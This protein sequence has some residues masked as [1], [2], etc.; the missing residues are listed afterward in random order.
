MDL[1]A[2]KEIY[3]FDVFFEEKRF[4]GEMQFADM[5]A[6]NW[7]LNTYKPKTILE[8]G[9]W[10]GSCTCLF[11]TF[12]RKY[13]G[14]VYSIDNFKGSPGSAQ[15]TTCH[16]AKDRFL[17]NIKRFGLEDTV[18]LLEGSSNDYADLDQTFDMVFIDAD[19]R[20]SQVKKDIENFAPK[21][22]SCGILSGHDFNH[23]DY[24]EKHIEEDY[25]T[26]RHH[27]VSKAVMELIDVMLVSTSGKNSVWYKI[28]EENGNNGRE[29]TKQRRSEL[30][31]A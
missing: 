30:Q 6:L 1:D 19:H 13:G 14:K 2:L 23:P 26:G 12:V 24:D 17:K 22:N 4:S 29:G 31:A 21:L 20:Y 11:G 18:T 8:I 3:P 5:V 15:E 9:A 25:V 7:I 28:G 27:G 16:V 10:T